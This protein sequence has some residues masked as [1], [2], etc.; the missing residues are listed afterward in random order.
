VTL[1]HEEPH[2]APAHDVVDLAAPEAAQ[3]SPLQFSNQGSLPPVVNGQLGPEAATASERAY[4]P[5]PAPLSAAGQIM[6][7]VAERDDRAIQEASQRYGVPEVDILAVITQE[8][9]GNARANAG[10]RDHGRHAAS[11]LMQVTE[12][13]WRS[14]Q[15][16]HP[17]LA[18]YGFA[19]Y[20]YDRRINILVG[21]AALK[22]KREALEGLGVPCVGPNATALTIMAFNAGE[23][24]VSAAYHLAEEGG[25]PNPAADCLQEQYLKPA[26]ARYPSVY[27]YYM[28]G[29]GRRLNP[30]HSVQ[31]AIDLKFREISRYPTQVQMLIAE[32]TEHDLA[33]GTVDDMPLQTEKQLA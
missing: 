21:T 4:G 9:R 3:P 31:R 14:T 11:G 25:S 1:K 27:S 19:A 16:R 23:G 24:I 12:G 7:G 6:A 10:G 33:E 13:T 30:H 26:I 8:S 22:D 29:G 28:T 15:N 18:Q 5:A 2:A 17:E 32:A 20:R